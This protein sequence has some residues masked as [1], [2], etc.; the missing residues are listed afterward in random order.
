MD[1][2]IGETKDEERDR[3]SS[4]LGTTKYQ[5]RRSND[6]PGATIVATSGIGKRNVPCP[7]LLESGVNGTHLLESVFV[8]MLE[9]HRAERE[10]IR[11]VEQP[12]FSKFCVKNFDGL[13]LREA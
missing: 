6:A 11:E 3:A 9:H 10:M 2:P 5:P 13:P 4:S 12:Q 7:H 8:G 1:F